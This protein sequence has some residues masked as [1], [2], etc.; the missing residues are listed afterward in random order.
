[1]IRII[2]YALII[3]LAYRLIKIGSSGGRVSPKHEP[4]SER[5]DTELIKDPQCGTYFLK[6]TGVSVQIDGRQMYFCSEK[7][8]DEYL[9]KGSGDRST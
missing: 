1:M 3:Y 8:R 4:A 7:C 2:L 5:E 6:R 9:K